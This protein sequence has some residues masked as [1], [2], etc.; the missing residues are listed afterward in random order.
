MKTQRKVARF[1]ERDLFDGLMPGED[2]LASGM[3]DS[4]ALEALIAWVQEEFAVSLE[5]E[6]FS[7]ENFASIPVLSA[8]LDRKRN[9][10]MP[11]RGNA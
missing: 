9:S 3:L 8:F 2:P 1:I 7:A 10:S 5:D 4:L 11:T 6:D